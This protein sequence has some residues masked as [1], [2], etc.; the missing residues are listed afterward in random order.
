MTWQELSVE[1]MYRLKNVL[2]VDVRSPCEH[3]AES[4]PGAINVPLLLDEERAEVGTVYNQQG[5]IAA[6]RLA[7]RTIAPK[8]PQLLDEILARRSQGQTLIIHC[9]RGGMRSEAV[10]SMLSMAGVDCF[11]LTGGYKAFRGYVLKDLQED[12]HK[13]EPLVLVGQTG[14][15]KTE[16]LK[17]LAKRGLHI[18]DLEAIANHRGSVFGGMGLGKQP[19][20]KD[21]ESR[22]WSA[23][24]TNAGKRVFLEAESRKI[25][26]LSLPDCVLDRIAAGPHI[27]VRGSVGRRAQRI[28]ADY[29]NAQ[30]SGEQDLREALEILPNLK[31]R[32]SNNLMHELQEH[33]IAGRI[34]QAIDLLLVEYYDPLYNKQIGSCRSFVLEVDSDDV[35]NA[36]ETIVQWAHKGASLAE[37]SIGT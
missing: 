21:F 36:T 9:W 32:L 4:I 28:A 10:C 3:Q 14:T 19:G 29:L 31:E 20:Q 11:R 8:I 24:K 25:G 16:I 1:Q 37:S 27:L 22:L 30:N 12:V 18:L 6:R 17:A 26:R 23:L 2:L 13:F 35:E 15:G 33:M 34:T 5:E 7:L